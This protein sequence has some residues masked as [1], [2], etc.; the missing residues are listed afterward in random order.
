M[1]RLIR[2][3]EQQD[4]SSVPH[5]PVAD[6]HQRWCGAEAAGVVRR[7]GDGDPQVLRGAGD[8]RRED[9]GAGGTGGD[10]VVAAGGV[11]PRGDGDEARAASHADGDRS[12]VCGTAG[13]RSE[14]VHLAKRGGLACDGQRAGS[15]HDVSHVQGSG[16]GSGGER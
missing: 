5:L 13:V 9:D 8:V 2:V 10:G 7:R 16:S 11:V 3:G 6:Q 12:D 4:R 15:A 1:V 14:A